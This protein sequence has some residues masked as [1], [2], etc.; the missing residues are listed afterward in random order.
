MIPNG[1]AY[2]N[3]PPFAN[4]GTRSA[5]A[6]A[7]Y[8]Q[9]MVPADTFPAEWANYFF[10]GATAGITRL[11]ADTGSIKKE[12]NNVL[13]DRGITPDATSD[14]QLLQAI[15]KIFTVQ[16][17]GNYAPHSVRNGQRFFINANQAITITLPAGDIGDVLYFIN[18]SQ[19]TATIAG[20]KLLAG[21]TLSLI[22]NGATGWLSVLT[23]SAAI[24]VVYPVNK[25]IYVQFPQQES[26]QK[27]WPWTTWQ[28]VNYDGAF[29][30]ASG[31]NANKFIEKTD[32]LVK[33]S[34]STAK[35]GLT[36][37]GTKSTISVSGGNHNHNGNTGKK[38]LSHSHSY[39]LGSSGGGGDQYPKG[40]YSTNE[41]WGKNTGEAN[42]SMDHSH[43]IPYSGNLSMSG[44]FTPSGSISGDDETRPTNYTIRVWK[45]IA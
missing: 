37:S 11:N 16:V 28:E 4:S 42:V 7:K 25:G 33:Q 26:P 10:H 21:E 45:R 14:T 34:Q 19:F 31:T 13:S 24:D 23:K 35:N 20:N 2:E 3:F 36:F 18:S 1:T 9:G 38:D 5:P 40:Y 8:A 39:W 12:I 43:S 29:F 22:Y 32:S 44:T 17:S 27:L 41:S 15:D 6:E 30:R